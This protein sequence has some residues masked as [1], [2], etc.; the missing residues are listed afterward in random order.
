MMARLVE[1]NVRSSPGAQTHRVFGWG[2]QGIGAPVLE[3]FSQLF[4]S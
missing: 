4:L 3:Q 1:R 2:T